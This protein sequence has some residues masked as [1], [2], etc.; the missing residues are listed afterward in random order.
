MAKPP[1]AGSKKAPAAS[2]PSL[3]LHIKYRP[4]DFAEVV[5]QENAVASLEAVLGGNNVPHTFLFTGPSGVGKTTLAR[6]LAKRL[7]CSD[8]GIMEIDAATHSGVDAMRQV[9]DLVRYKALGESTT[10]LI[11]VDEAHAASK[12]AFQSL[13]LAIEE[14]PEHC[15]W[16]LCTTESGRIPETIK[17]RCHAYDLKPVGWEALEQYLA[18]VVEEEQYETPEDIIGLIARKASGSV[19]QAL[20]YLSMCAGT[21][22][23]KVAAA[24]LETLSDDGEAIDLAR[25]LV[26]PRGGWVEA[27]KKLLSLKEQNAES[28]RIVIANYAAAVLSNTK[29]ENEARKILRV[30][31]AFSTPFNASECAAPLYLA[32]GWLLLEE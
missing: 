28:V 20:V 25:F 11:I 29:T 18:L 17:T 9:T 12:A 24:L 23:K 1:I 30:L 32:V 3:P 13:L 4:K 15:Y 19:R 2:A 21:S 14:P 31:Q 27:Q 22:D 5:G 7:G 8:T 10:R 26:N 16:C 6:I